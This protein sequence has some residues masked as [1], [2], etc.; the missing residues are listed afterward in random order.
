MRSRLSK[1]GNQ[2]SKIKNKWGIWKI[3]WDG[4]N[5]R[6]ERFSKRK[7]ELNFSNQKRDR[8]GQKWGLFRDKFAWISSKIFLRQQTPH[9]LMTFLCAPCLNGSKGCFYSDTYIKDN[10]FFK[11][12]MQKVS[13]MG[14]NGGNQFFNFGV[15]KKGELDFSKILV[16]NQSLTHYGDGRMCSLNWITCRSVWHED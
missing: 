8:K 5:K 15:D 2:I 6:G 10:N 9:P 1:W 11:F 14:T 16:G 12:S 3:L 4:E 7:G 13:Q